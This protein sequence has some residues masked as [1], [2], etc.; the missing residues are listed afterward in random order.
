METLNPETIEVMYFVGVLA[1][2]VF[3]YSI[4]DADKWLHHLDKKRDKK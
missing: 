3:L 1:I 4:F 2:A